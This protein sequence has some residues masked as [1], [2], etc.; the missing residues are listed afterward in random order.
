MADTTTVPRVV[1][2]L[3][4]AAADDALANPRTAAASAA[5][6]ENADLPPGRGLSGYAVMIGYYGRMFGNS[7]A[8]D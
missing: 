1:V 2:S 8:T 6:P 7:V 5:V 3:V 4:W